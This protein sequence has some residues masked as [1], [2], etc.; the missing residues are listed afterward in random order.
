MTPATRFFST[1]DRISSALPGGDKSVPETMVN[2]LSGLRLTDV[3]IARQKEQTARK[4]IKEELKGRPGFG[5]FEK[6]Y[7]K[8]EQLNKL[9]PEELLLYSLYKQLEKESLE[10][11]KKRKEA[12]PIG[13]PR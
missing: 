11:S 10:A 1:I 6:V 12:L 4:A 9:T 3:D 7:I 2:L 13:L 5:A 8:P